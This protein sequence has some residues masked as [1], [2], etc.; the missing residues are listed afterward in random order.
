MQTNTQWNMYDPCFGWV[1]FFQ[2]DA[3]DLTT[4]QETFS[5]M[6]IMVSETG[7]YLQLKHSTHI[8]IRTWNPKLRR[9]AVNEPLKAVGVPIFFWRT[10]ISLMK[11][12]FLPAKADCSIFFAPLDL[13]RWVAHHITVEFYGLSF[14]CCHVFR[15]LVEHWNIYNREWD[16]LWP[17]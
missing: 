13:N 17:S 4:F 11:K 9:W 10:Y 16:V 7:Y 8:Q 2:N 6:M 5:Y 12:F 1:F 14:F 3:N 15:K